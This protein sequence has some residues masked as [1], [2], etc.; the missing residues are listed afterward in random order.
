MTPL[1]PERKQVMRAFDQETGKE[2]IPNPPKRYLM[3]LT[4]TGDQYDDW[5]RHWEQVT[6]REGVIR[7]VYSL[8]D[9][10]EYDESYICSE[11]AT[12]TNT[13]HLYTFL[14]YC[15]EAGYWTEEL[16]KEL[17]G[18]SFDDFEAELLNAYDI[19]KDELTA[20][21]LEEVRS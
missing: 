8:R 16:I 20:I 21:Y 11:S 5:N 2:I 15:H 6:S 3:L 17:E 7:R 4:W 10:I 9:D 1:F 19:S 18:Y 12:L 14:R 13:W